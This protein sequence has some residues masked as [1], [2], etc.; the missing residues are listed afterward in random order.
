MQLEIPTMKSQGAAKNEANNAAQAGSA[1]S[2][3]NV[4]V[5][6]PAGDNNGFFT[7]NEKIDFS[8][9]TIE[10]LFEE[11]VDFDTFSKSDF[12]AVKV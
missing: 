3:E 11:Q 5:A 9:V 12:R 6:A 8:K 10:P 2:A 4:E 7:P 1:A